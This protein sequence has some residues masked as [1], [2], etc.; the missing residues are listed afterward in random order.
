LPK[1]L[2]NEFDDSYTDQQASD[3]YKREANLYQWMDEAEKGEKVD[4]NE[5]RYR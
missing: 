5:E 3:I 2:K 4:I 1:H